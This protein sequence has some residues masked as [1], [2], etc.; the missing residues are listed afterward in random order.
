VTYGLS[1]F[2]AAAAALYLTTQTGAGSPTIGKDYILLSV[3]AAVIGGVSLFGGRGNLL[4]T[5]IGASILTLIGNLVFV[6]RVSS[7][8]QP[9][10]SGVI[11]LVAVLASSLAERSAR[12]RAR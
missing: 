4:G 6:L 2:F 7:Y 11:L 8:W 9:V 10:M 5:V 3:A 12:R 1:G